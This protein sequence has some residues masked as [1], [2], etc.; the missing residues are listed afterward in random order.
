MLN[1]SS[2]GA[3]E[4]PYPFAPAAVAS[5][6]V[7]LPTHHPLRSIGLPAGALPGLALG[8]LVSSVIFAYSRPKR[9][10]DWD[11]ACYARGGA[12]WA[13]EEYPYLWAAG[14]LATVTVVAL[15]I[16]WFAWYVRRN[17][18]VAPAEAET[19]PAT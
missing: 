9:H 12:C 11:E 14:L 2:T 5:S 3:A 13:H 16:G 19:E 10:S 18:R 4:A 17:G 8:W 15:L 1:A 7:S 6:P